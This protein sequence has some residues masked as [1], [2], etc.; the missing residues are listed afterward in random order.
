MAN[1]E[2]FIQYQPVVT[3]F[4]VGSFGRDLFRKEEKLY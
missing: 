2:F 3:V 4:K 1:R